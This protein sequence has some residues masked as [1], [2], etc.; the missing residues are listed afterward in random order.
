MDSEPTH[1]V[2]RGVVLVFPH[3]RLLA[4]DNRAVSPNF[5]KLLGAAPPLQPALSQIHRTRISNVRVADK[6]KQ[7]TPTKLGRFQSTSIISCSTAFKLGDY[8][9]IIV[10]TRNEVNV[11]QFLLSNTT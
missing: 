8:N 4:D 7:L 10:S 6:D 2:C 11:L 1:A 5:E 3:G 9:N